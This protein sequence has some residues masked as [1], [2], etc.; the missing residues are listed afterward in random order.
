MPDLPVYRVD[1][2]DAA[3]VI[4]LCSVRCRALMRLN[5]YVA[6]PPNVWL[7][8]YVALLRDTRHLGFLLWPP[9][10]VLP[11]QTESRVASEKRHPMRIRMVGLR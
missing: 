3:E 6:I 4:A 7:N 5:L 11:H 8:R 9:T 10:L 2:G 1:I